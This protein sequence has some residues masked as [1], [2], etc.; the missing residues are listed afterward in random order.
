MLVIDERK[1][2][3]CQKIKNI[4]IHIVKNYRLK[5]LQQHIPNNEDLADITDA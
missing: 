2:S 1:Y 5:S 3:T 4:C